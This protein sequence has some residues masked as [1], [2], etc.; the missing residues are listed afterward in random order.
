MREAVLSWHASSGRR[1]APK[2]RGDWPLGSGLRILG[3]SGRGSPHGLALHPASAIRPA[4][5]LLDELM[6]P[7][8]RILPCLLLA[9]AAASQ[10]PVD[11]TTWTAE[12]YQAVSGFPSGVWNVASGGQSVTQTTNGQPTIFYSDFGLF[13]RRVEGQITV[14]GS[15]DDLAGFVLGYQPGD[16]GNPN[17]D[18]LLLDWKRATQSYNFGAPSC[19]PGSTAA[20]GLALSRV[21]GLP[22]ADEFW[23]HVNLDTV[24]CSTAGDAV[25]ELQRAATLGA[26]AWVRNQ[27]YTFRI[28]YTPNRVV[29]HVDGVPQ[30]DL[31]G[32]FP[33]G[34]IGFYNFSQALVTYNAFTT[35]HLASFSNYGSGFPGTLGVPG[36]TASALPVLGTSL[37]LR[38]TSAASVPQI[39]LLALGLQPEAVPTPLGGWLLVNI[40]VTEGVLVPVAP[41]VALSPLQVPANAAIA[42]T[43]V[44]A[45]FVH[46]DAGAAVGLAFS[47]GLALAI[48]D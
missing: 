35:D 48:G 14:T 41:A 30:I 8:F 29:V 40:V 43:V 12:S 36:L 1:G 23:G 38:M 25:T 33:D 32:S 20:R 9:A 19:T 39:G 16:V 28:D 6:K 15:D 17:A 31:V 4:V 47:P 27:T 7:M 11:L 2:A 18:Y 5:P 22:T 26:T 10:T 45:Q 34:R 42:G 3:P 24:P 44:Y 21:Q 13:S 37:D 46:F